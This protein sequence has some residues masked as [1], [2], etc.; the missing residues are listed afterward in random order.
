[1]LRR[2]FAPILL[3]TS[4]ASL[5]ACSQGPTDDASAG[6]D[7]VSASELRLC[8]AVRGNGESI[9]THFASLAH[10]VEHYGLVTG[11]AG[12]SSGSITTFTY[13]SI[14]MDKSVHVCGG[15][16]C[17]AEAEAARV[18]LALK[19]LEGYSSTVGESEEAASIK[20]L[21]VA[22]QK[23]KAEYDAK[24]IAGLGA[25]SDAEAARRLVDVLS[26]PE[27]RSIVNPEALAMLQNPSQLSFAVS[28]MKTAITQLGAFSVE[29]NRLFFRTGVLDWKALAGLIGRVGDFYAGY[30]PVDEAAK[31]KWLDACADSTRDMPWADAARVAIAGGGTCGEAFSKIVAD[32]RAKVRSAAPGSSRSRIDDSVGDPRSPLKKLLSTAVLEGDAA[33]K[34]KAERTKYAAGQ[35]PTGNVPFT[36][37]F[38]DVRFGY[39]GNE[40]DLARVQSN[41]KGFTDL[42]TKKMT[43]LGN[44]KWRDVLSASPAEPG[45]S[46]F[47]ELGGGR[48]SAG[49]WSDLAPSLAL[50]NLGC[51]HVVY[52][53]RTG[54]EAQFAAKIAKNLGMSEREWSSLYDLSNADSSYSRS[55]AAADGVWCTRWNDF[56]D[57]QM[58][59]AVL[60]AYS[61]PLETRGGFLTPLRPYEGTTSR[62]S[63]VGCTPGMSGGATYPR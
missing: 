47:V 8:A 38:D 49:G 23:L 37:S 35:Y 21:F 1:M 39:W 13:E 26:I 58:P 59:A 44:V 55:V 33:T 60:D 29:D 57:A 53:T 43:S 61:S 30:G 50:Q 31:S 25:D 56:T 6:E 17:S 28:E 7:A 41:P 40:A 5:G 16:P 3:G 22:I 18:A 24:G 14:L 54:D 32:Y 48:I 4:I 36:P 2:L 12:G 9:L 62:S 52:V 45:L 11:M 15:E 51:Q 27:V 63:R 10:I 46:R 42:K 20:G 19:S 34:Y